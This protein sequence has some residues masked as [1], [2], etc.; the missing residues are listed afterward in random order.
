MKGGALLGPGRGG[1]GDTVGWVTIREQVGWGDGG[2]AED[3]DGVGRPDDPRLTRAS[4]GM[5]QGA[6]QGG[7]RHVDVGG[8]IVHPS[9]HCGNVREAGGGGKGRP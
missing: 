2:R 9:A 4:L 5:F 6:K 8:A 7:G 3:F 1:A